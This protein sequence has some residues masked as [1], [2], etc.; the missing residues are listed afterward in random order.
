VE[1]FRTEGPPSDLEVYENYDQIALKT[2]NS[3]YVLAMIQKSKDELLSRSTSVVASQGQKKKGRKLWF[4]MA[5]FDENELTARRKYLFIVNDRPNLMEEPKK[6]LS[7]DCEVVL[8]SEVL[9]KPYTNENARRIATLRQVQENIRKDTGEVG[10]DNKMLDICG[11]L[12]NQALEAALVK[13]D[14]SPAM[15]SRLSAPAGVDFSHLNLG[16]GKIQMLPEHDIIKVK[17]RLGE[18]VKE[19]IKDL[20]ASEKER[21]RQ[22]QLAPKA[23]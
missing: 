19:W 8:G 5:A 12:A 18:P 13:L 10:S 6:D 23:Y 1:Y 3:A 9:D 17:M 11:M 4:T 15:A 21:K 16:R 2:G 20:E 7:F 22:E 14:S